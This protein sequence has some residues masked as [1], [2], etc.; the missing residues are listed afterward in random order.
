MLFRVLTPAPVRA[1]ASAT[2][3]DPLGDD[4]E[5]P[6]EESIFD[7]PRTS[8]GQVDTGAVLRKLQLAAPQIGA[9]ALTGIAVYGVSRVVITLASTLLNLTL[10]QAVSIGFGAGVVTAAGVASAAYFAM[11]RITIRPEYVFRLALH[12]LRN[13]Q[14]VVDAVGKPVQGGNLRAYT[15]REGHYAF[16]AINRIG[17]VN[18]RVQMLFSVQGPKQQ[19]MV[20]LEAEKMGNTTEFTLLSVDVLGHHA[21]APPL[22]VEGLED[23][24][25]VRGQ[26]RGFLQS[27][28]VRYIEQSKPSSEDAEQQANERL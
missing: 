19:A 4:S 18:P 13:S 7:I 6:K 23:R 16:N 26:L 2:S 11:Q 24:L 14:S 10:T 15:I 28:R 22:L 21:D 17:W 12:R 3:S 9:V 20:S 5:P 27:E 25:K 1:L 8:S